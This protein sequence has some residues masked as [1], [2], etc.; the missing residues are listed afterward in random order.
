MDTS[1]VIPW[2][3]GD[4]LE[5]TDGP[6]SVDAKIRDRSGRYASERPLDTNKSGLCAYERCEKME[7]FLLTS[8]DR[9][10]EA[11]TG[12]SVE[13]VDGGSLR[14]GLL[15]VCCEKI[16]RDAMQTSDG[17]RVCS[18]CAERIK[19]YREFIVIMLIQISL[20]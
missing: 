9:E 20:Y 3:R 6:H 7:R 18:P 13:L 8:S 19:R 14:R 2:P 4:N 16:P 15:C 11:A 10:I 1:F 17:H 5:E 12:Y